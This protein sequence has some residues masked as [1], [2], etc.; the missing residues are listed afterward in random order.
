MVI[1]VICGS[2]GKDLAVWRLVCFAQ[3]AVGEH[4]R[5]GIGEQ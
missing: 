1:P 3:T 4:S 2:W 5:I